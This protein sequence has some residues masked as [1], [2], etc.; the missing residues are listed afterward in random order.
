MSPLTRI[1]IIIE[2]AMSLVAHLTTLKRQK[3]MSFYNN[4]KLTYDFPDTRVDSNFSVYKND[5]WNYF[6]INNN[7]AVK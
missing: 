1:H 5:R 4:F 7:S 2:H 3:P 6:T